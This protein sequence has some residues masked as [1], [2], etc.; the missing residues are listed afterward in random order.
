[1]FVLC[2]AGAGIASSSRG[3]V[4]IEPVSRNDE[5]PLRSVAEVEVEVG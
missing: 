1:M 5:K 2:V 4:A 3:L